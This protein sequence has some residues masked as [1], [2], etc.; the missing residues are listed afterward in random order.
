MLI[1]FFLSSCAIA[2]IA[3][4]WRNILNDHVSLK[5]GIE[6]KLKFFHKIFTCGSCFTYWISLL[7]VVL[8]DPLDF[9][10]PFS[11]EFFNLFVHWM[12]VAFL[13]VIMR[14]T[15]ISIQEL[16][17]YQVHHLREDHSH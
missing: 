8:S 14:F 2:G 7:F 10:L 17:Y 12:A 4:L 6:N 13:S 16:V 9:W 5:E 1:N 15:Y 11:A 3:V